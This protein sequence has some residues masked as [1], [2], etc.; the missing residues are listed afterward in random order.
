MFTRNMC[1]IDCNCVSNNTYKNNVCMK[2]SAPEKLYIAINELTEDGRT[3]VLDHRVDYP[4]CT[5]Y[6]RTDVFLMKAKKWFEKSE[7]ID[8]CQ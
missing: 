2:S 5:E 3:F 1:S 8:I 6:T 7:G 4:I